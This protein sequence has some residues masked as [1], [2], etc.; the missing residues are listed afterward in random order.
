MSRCQQDTV[1]GE[2]CGDIAPYELEMPG[3]TEHDSSHWA[4]CCGEHAVQ[5]LESGDGAVRGPGGH[6]IA[7][8]GDGE[9][10]EVDE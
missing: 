7:I 4:P 2:P 5:A 9:L 10:V 3:A 1:Y 8:D 6:T